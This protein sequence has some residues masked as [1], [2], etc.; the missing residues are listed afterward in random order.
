MNAYE[1]STMK[2]I[3]FEV[4]MR[5]VPHA[6]QPNQSSKMPDL[7]EKKWILKEVWEAMQEAMAKC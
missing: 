4:W 5:Y 2:H 1:S 6:H 3:P 7:K